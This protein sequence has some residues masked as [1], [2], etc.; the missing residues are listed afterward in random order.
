[1]KRKQIQ[2]ALIGAGR[3]GKLHG[4]NI[5][6][7]LT[8]VKLAAVA[9]VP[10]EA[11]TEWAALRG[12]TRVTENYQELLED[13]DI[14][15][16][17]ICSSTDTHAEIIIDAAKAGKHIFCE[18]PIAASVPR[19]VEAL[20]AVEEAGVKLQVG[21]NRR[22]DPHFAKARELVRAGKIGEL[23][24]LHITSRDPEPPPIEYLGVSG[25][26]FMDMTIHDFDMARFL[27]DS[28]VEEVYAAGAVLVDPAIG[29]AGDIDTAVIQ[30]KFANGAIGTIDNS[31]KAAYGYDQRIEVFGSKGKVSVDNVPESN[32]VLSSSESVISEKPQYF[33]LERYQQSFVR[34]LQAFF[35]AVSE[36]RP[37]PVTGQDGLEPVL[38]ALAANLSMKENRPV[39]LD[40]IRKLYGL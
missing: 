19:I 31:R 17:L 40:E 9:S 25:G 14:D 18:K 2:V 26:M 20:N 22:F 23:H 5:L 33:F 34:E 32:A 4:D 8:E 36:N 39:K 13:P 3:I 35:E 7:Q 15:A 21:F 12:I 27:S 30:M 1:M 29:E 11:A 28:D 24:L 38:I 10:I 37:T 16:V 6:A